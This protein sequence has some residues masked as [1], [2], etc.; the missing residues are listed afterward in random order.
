MKNSRYQIESERFVLEV[1]AIGAEIS[2]LFDKKTN[3]ELFYDGS[4]SWKCTDHILFPF[5]GPDDHYD[6][7]GVHYGCKT[8][9]GF[10]R[11]KEVQ[12]LDKKNDEILFCLEED[13]DTLACYPFPFKLEILYKLTS[14]SLIRS[15]RVISKGRDLYYEI[16]DHPAFSI[17]FDKAILYLP[18]KKVYYYPRPD[19]VLQEK[20]L[21]N[22]PSELHPT[23]ELFKEYETIVIDNPGENL[24]LD[25][26]RGDSL[27]FKYDA[28]YIAIW[29][30]VKEED[31]FICI[32][33]WWG[34]PPYKGMPE[35]VSLRKAIRQTADFSIYTSEIIIDIL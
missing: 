7:G 22:L 26:G 11:T 23:K 13:E 28:P 21:L 34:L 8:Q 14:N 30:P 16:G 35:E 4:K 29:S 18:K 20:S 15:Y 19:F 25:T 12:L 33:P 31:D 24:V 27:T 9:H 10:V 32:E 3:R 6:F 5:I 2:R 17:D 1:S